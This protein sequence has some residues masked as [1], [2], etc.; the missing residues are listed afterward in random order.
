MTAILLPDP[1]EYNG[2]RYSLTT[3]S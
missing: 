1:I 3:K 2:S